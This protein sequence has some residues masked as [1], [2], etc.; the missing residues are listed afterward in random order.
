MDGYHKPVLLSEVLEF[1]NVL[2]SR[3]FIDCTLGDG[4]YSLGILEK[5]GNVVGIDLDPEAIKRAEARFEKL[6]IDEK[7]YRLVKGNFRNIDELLGPE[8]LYV[9]D[10]IHGI[11]FDLGVS[12]LQLEDESRGFSFS[13]EAKLDM[14]MDPELS[15]L[16]MDLVNGL[17][18]GELIE[19]LAKYGESTDLRIVNAIIGARERG[20]IET[21][22]Q[23]ASIVEKAVGGRKS[24]QIHPAT[25]IF[26]ALRIAVNDELH[27]LEEALPNALDLL[28]S[29]GK[30]VI[31]SFHSLEDRIV[32]NVFKNWVDQQLGQVLTEKPILPSQQEIEENPRSRSAKLRVFQKGEISAHEFNTPLGG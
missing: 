16:A 5:G 11:V 23:L 15:V 9:R 18:K 12:S 32:K 17:H 21:T 10:D 31:V 27:S 29:N 7:R 13:K 3:W 1:L 20:K 2:E 26:Q 4:G 30:I 19:L 28:T 6:G 8:S 24:G 25:T 14:R 22:T